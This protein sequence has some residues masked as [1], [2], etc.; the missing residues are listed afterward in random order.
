MRKAGIARTIRKATVPLNRQYEECLHTAGAGFGVLGVC[1]NQSYH[2][3]L[4]YQPPAD[5]SR[6]ISVVSVALLNPAKKSSRS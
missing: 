4:G 2:E 6:K 1:H 5:R 3:S